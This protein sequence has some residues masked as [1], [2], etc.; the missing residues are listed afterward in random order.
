MRKKL[1]IDAI[2]KDSRRRV[3]KKLI[4]PDCGRTTRMM[5]HPRDTHFLCN[6]CTAEIGNIFLEAIGL[7]KGV[8]K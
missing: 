1:D 7:Q 4:C 6:Q 8:R 3:R 5:A 2:L